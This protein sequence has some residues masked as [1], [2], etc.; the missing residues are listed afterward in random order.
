MIHP[1]LGAASRLGAL[2]AREKQSRKML[3]CMLCIFVNPRR[4]TGGE[5]E[6]PNPTS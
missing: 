6:Y 5:D 2:I 1:S 4:S 3:G